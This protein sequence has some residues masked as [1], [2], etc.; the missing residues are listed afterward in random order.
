MCYYGSVDEDGK[1]ATLFIILPR[2]GGSFGGLLF[3]WSKTMDRTCDRCGAIIEPATVNDNPHN[4]ILLGWTTESG[5]TTNERVNVC[6]KCADAF[7]EWMKD[8]EL[9]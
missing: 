8:A 9:G 1:A 2:H 7:E 5:F 3:F 6:S 4:L